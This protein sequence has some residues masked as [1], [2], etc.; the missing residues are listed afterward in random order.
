MDF[1]FM[2]TRE[3]QTVEDCLTVFEEIRDVGVRHIGFKDIG[4]ERKTLEELNRRIKESGAISY[5]EVVAT[6]A[7]EVLRSAKAAREIGVD[8]LMGGTDLDAVLEILEGSGIGYYPFP[9][10]PAGHPTKLG[11]TPDL[12]ENHC[13]YFTER[14]CAGADLLAFRATEADP[15]ELVRAARRGLGDDGELVVAGSVDGAARI[16]ALAQAG[17]DAFTIG[18]AAFDGAF[19]P[20]KGSLR[21]QLRDILTAAASTGP[22]IETAQAS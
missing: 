6:S 5:M 7:E 13:R 1:I 22:E 21:G 10:R 11:G 9:G 17:A 16:R 3:D 19:S 8:R 12:I 15:L 2:L 20:R 4:V 18:S 14:G